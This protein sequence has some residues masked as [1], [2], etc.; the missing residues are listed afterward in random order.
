M[1]NVREQECSDW[2]RDGGQVLIAP[3]VISPHRVCFLWSLSSYSSCLPSWASKFDSNQSKV[4][5]LNVHFKYQPII[6]NYNFLKSWNSTKVGG[7]AQELE[8]QA[9]SIYPLSLEE[10][11]VLVAS[12]S[13]PW[14]SFKKFWTLFLKG[15]HRHTFYRYHLKI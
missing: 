10:K 6:G 4:V 9:A 12:S 3:L 5:I 7:A 8:V 15:S 1:L 2:V 14:P 11:W 13:M